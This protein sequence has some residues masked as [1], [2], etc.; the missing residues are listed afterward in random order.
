MPENYL[1]ME[2]YNR[3]CTF[4]PMQTIKFKRGE[5]IMEREI[6]TLEATEFVVNT[7]APESIS[8]EERQMLTHKIAIVHAIKLKYML[9]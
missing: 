5:K 2:L 9:N 3:I 4:S 1:V 7:F 6:P 8:W